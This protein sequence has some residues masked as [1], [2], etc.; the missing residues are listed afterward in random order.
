MWCLG[1]FVHPNNSAVLHQLLLKSWS[2]FH[3]VCCDSHLTLETSGFLQVGVAAADKT[4]LSL[5]HAAGELRVLK[6]ARHTVKWRTGLHFVPETSK[7]WILISD[8]FCSCEKN[9]RAIPAYSWWI[10]SIMRLWCGRVII[11]NDWT[12][13]VCLSLCVSCLSFLQSLY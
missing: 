1:H 12:V 7:L 2:Y 5:R 13:N 11:L 10:I 4:V 6:R 8:P 9:I 3:A